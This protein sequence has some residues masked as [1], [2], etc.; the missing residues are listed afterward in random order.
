M[1]YIG[2]TRGLVLIFD[3]HQNLRQIIGNTQA[4]LEQGAVTCL[5]VH[6][7]H[8]RLVCGHQQGF[9]VFWDIPKAKVIK[10][11]NADRNS[12]DTAIASIQFLDSENEVVAIDDKVRQKFIRNPSSTLSH[13]L[14]FV[15]SGYRLPPHNPKND[16]GLRLRKQVVSHGEK[17]QCHLLHRRPPY[18]QGG[19]LVG[20]LQPDRHG[21][22]VQVA[23][24]GH[25]TSNR[26]LL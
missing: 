14:L 21:N 6:P 18:W 9:I 3:F 4:G 10:I 16:D 25:E 24:P 8:E 15:F 26:G 22:P 7:S 5:D 12:R 17:G 20:C 23:G 2:T 13:L 11:I 1:V 19:P